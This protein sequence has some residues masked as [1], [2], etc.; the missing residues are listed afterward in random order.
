MADLANPVT[1]DGDYD[2]EIN[3]RMNQ[4]IVIEKDSGSATITAKFLHDGT[5]TDITGGSCT[6]TSGLQVVVPG[7]GAQK[8]RFTVASA[9]SL[10]ARILVSPVQ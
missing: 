8:L 1:A 9:S 6:S 2:V 10:S 3:G 7:S 4:S 5:E